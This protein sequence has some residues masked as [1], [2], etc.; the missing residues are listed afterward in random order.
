MNDQTTEGTINDL[1]GKAKDAAGG[2]TGDAA[3]QAE[4]KADQLVGKAQSAMGDAAEKVSGAA[5]SAA[6]Y[7]SDLAGR[8]GSKLHGTAQTVKEGAASAGGRIY[9]AGAQAGDYVG[10][11]VERQPLLSL[12]GVAALGYFIGYLVHSPSSPFAPRR[13]FRDRWL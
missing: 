7:A 9:E 12:L 4:G 8:A 3:T 5:S 10:Y 13:S 6:D 11:A 1:K 2:L